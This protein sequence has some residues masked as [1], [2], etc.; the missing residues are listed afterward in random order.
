M[1]KRLLLAGCL[2]LSAI[3]LGTALLIIFGGA[4]LARG[5]FF[6]GLSD[7]LLANPPI[8][9][10]P[11]ITDR[12]EHGI[13]PISLLD[14]R[15]TGEG[16]AA[17]YYIEVVKSLAAREIEAMGAGP[18]IDGWVLSD[19]EYE[20]F[21]EGVR[22]AECD[23]SVESLVLNDMPVRLAP[24]VDIADNLD[25][26]SWFRR[27]AKAVVKRGEEHESDGEY[28]AALQRYEATVK[29]GLDIEEGRESLLQV[30]VGVAVQKMGAERLRKLCELRGESEKARQWE[31]YLKDLEIFT[32]KFKD[33]TNRLVRNV[34]LDVESAADRL[35]ILKHDDD[36]LFRREVLTG[37]AWAMALARDA[38]EPELRKAAES[39]PDPYVR[40]AARNALKLGDSMEESF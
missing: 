26:L 14:S 22:Q 7:E 28:E 18:P 40:E 17:A 2:G 11:G 5:A 21:L 27:F 25:H 10:E 19:E 30:F 20:T 39:D 35:W 3:V 15:P 16:N 38:V 31:D 8:A 9:S 4:L 37:L 32:G 13:D 24:A 34:S 29:F 6:F 1:N 36:P 12:I 23:F 33:K